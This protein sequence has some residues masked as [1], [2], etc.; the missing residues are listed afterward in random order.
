MCWNRRLLQLAC[1][2]CALSSRYA[3]C[4]EYFCLLTG[5]CCCVCYHAAARSLCADFSSL[6]AKFEMCSQTR[7][8]HVSKG[9]AAR[10]AVK[11]S[12]AQH[13]KIL[14]ARLTNRQGWTC[15]RDRIH[16]KAW[17]A[18]LGGSSARPANRQEKNCN[19][20][21]RKRPFVRPV[22]GLRWRYSA[23]SPHDIP[24]TIAQ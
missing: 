8:P 24:I 18:R 2:C 15:A 5:R 11:Q 1:L 17:P 21:Q 4:A 3:L 7:P 10:R 22:E 19:T 9:P 16:K 23:T 20:T 14:I 12:A 6:V 13:V